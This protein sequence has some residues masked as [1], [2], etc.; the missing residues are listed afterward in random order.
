MSRDIN[1]VQHIRKDVFERELDKKEF[2][3]SIIK[4]KGYE[5]WHNDYHIS[6]EIKGTIEEVKRFMNHFQKYVDILAIEDEE[7]KKLKYLLIVFLAKYAINIYTN[8]IYEDIYPSVVKPKN[9]KGID[10]DEVLEF[11]DRLNEKYIELIG[12]E[13]ELPFC[14]AKW[15]KKY[16]KLFFHSTCLLFITPGNKVY[17]S[18][19]VNSINYRYYHGTIDKILKE[20]IK[21][22]NPKNPFYLKNNL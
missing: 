8:I 17:R 19:S 10:N 15:G 18:A 14:Q 12:D 16:V 5:E 21:F 7:T 2:L 13:V 1:K 20:G 3:D 4:I 9:I 22:E 11:V 6:D